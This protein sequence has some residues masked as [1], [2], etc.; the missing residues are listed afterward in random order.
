MKIDGMVKKLEM[1]S[2]TNTNTINLN[3]ILERGIT[4]LLGYTTNEY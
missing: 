3:H 1:S 4:N 2:F